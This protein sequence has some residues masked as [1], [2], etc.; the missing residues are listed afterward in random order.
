[1]AGL[2]PVQKDKKK[3]SFFVWLRKAILDFFFLDCSVFLQTLRIYAHCL[4]SLITIN[5]DACVFDKKKYKFF[6]C[7]AY[8]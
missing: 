3:K 7:V 6:F 8:G 5:C 1:M 2:D 4:L